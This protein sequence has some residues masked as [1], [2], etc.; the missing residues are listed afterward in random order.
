MIEL[1]FRLWSV[2]KKELIQL[3]RDKTS[4]IL[5]FTQPLLIMLLLGYT[6]Q[7][8]IRDVPLVVVDQ[9]QTPISQAVV[10]Q[11]TGS[12]VFQVVAYLG[13]EDEAK[14]WIK[15]GKAEAAL[16]IE[17]NF[18]SALTHGGEAKA[19]LLV[20]GSQPLLTKSIMFSARNLGTAINLKAIGEYKKHLEALLNIT[21]S[22]LTQALMMRGIAYTPLQINPTL[23]MPPTEKSFSLNPAQE[24]QQ[25][26][27]EQISESVHT[28]L[29]LSR[30]IN[31]NLEEAAEKQHDL[32]NTLQDFA[33]LIRS[34]GLAY[35]DFQLL[36]TAG[37]LDKIAEGLDQKPENMSAFKHA[38][39][40]ANAQ[41]L[42][43]MPKLKLNTQTPAVSIGGHLQL[44]QPAQLEYLQ[45]LHLPQMPGHVNVRYEVL[46]NGDKLRTLDLMAPLIIALSVAFSALI[47][48]VPAVAI[49]RE[50]G[51][52]ERLLTTP[53]RRG[54]ILLGKVLSRL[55]FSI[56]QALLMIVLGILIFRLNVSGSLW[57]LTLVLIPVSISHLG[58]GIM[59]SS[60][61]NS[62]R[63]ARYAIPMITMTSIM[64]SGFMVPVDIMPSYIRVFSNLVPLKYANDVLIG[65]MIKGAS[66][67][68]YTGSLL[69]LVG[70]SVFFFISGIYAFM[71]RT[72]G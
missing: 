40:R 70:F 21:H 6:F 38:A 30:E 9:D 63:T 61:A 4:I 57:I 16:I 51:T 37:V 34:K 11:F 65:V 64:L 29:A 25:A 66:L 3:F 14:N 1:S 27:E 49:E 5:I 68:D 43:D 17:K 31:K 67:S 60:L 28:Y 20:D 23:A 36:Y 58:M 41:L 12:N 56:T 26:F 33:A 48:T 8:G 2:V 55:I 13:S 47:L 44:Q 18:S 15:E 22:L 10:H 52:L 53:I 42:Q 46:Y 45:N 50:Q 39:A 72:R 69:A 19:K 35:N 7:S 24:Q 71:W 32:S 59:V 54:D 62:E